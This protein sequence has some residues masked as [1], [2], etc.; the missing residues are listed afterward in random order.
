MKVLISC[1]TNTASIHDLV[2]RANYHITEIVMCGESHPKV[3]E[4]FAAKRRLPVKRF[5]DVKLATKYAQA[6][7]AYWN[8]KA[9]HT[10]RLIRL[11]RGNM[12]LVYVRRAEET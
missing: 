4:D 1:D 11:A 9:S 10:D 2:E 7:V 3:V 5:S 6:L 8:G 12:L